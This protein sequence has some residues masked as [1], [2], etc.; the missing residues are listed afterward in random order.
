MLVWRR[1]AAP[2]PISPKKNTINSS[3]VNSPALEPNLL[4][5]FARPIH[6]AGLRYIIA[7]SVGSM[8]YSEPRLTL[9]ID[10]PLLV[11]LKD[12]PTLLSLFQEPEYYCPPAD[13][14]ASEIARDCRSHFNII[15]IPT[16]LKADF[17]PGN[18]DSTFAW[19]WQNRLTQQTPHGPIHIAPAEYIILWKMIFYKEGKS[20]KHLRDIQRILDIQPILP[21]QD[22]LDD[23]IKTHALTDIWSTFQR[24]FL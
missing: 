13:V 12:I 2:I 20:Q 19:A 3:P 7:G 1:A 10:I 16:G 5:L 6:D 14:I 4:A 8:H 9:D 17:Y 11:S 24:P 22:F 15:H 21:H 18:R 23:A